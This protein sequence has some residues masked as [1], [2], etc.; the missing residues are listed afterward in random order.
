MSSADPYLE[1][2]TVLELFQRILTD[3]NLALAHDPTTKD[4]KKLIEYI[5]RQFFKAVQDKPM[6]LMEVSVDR[7]LS[8]LTALLRCDTLQA[9]FPKSRG[10]LSKLRMGD[11]DYYES[12]EDEGPAFKVS[13]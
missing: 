5:L 11:L 9:F 10:Q 13:H 1:Q 8:R 7:H 3:D 6:L 12:S 4:L 2:P